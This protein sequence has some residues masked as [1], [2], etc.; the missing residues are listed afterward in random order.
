MLHTN[1]VSSLNLKCI[2]LGCIDLHSTRGVPLET[3]DRIGG[4]GWRVHSVPAGP[5]DLYES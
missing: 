3:S 1:V 4:G 5:G 2:G